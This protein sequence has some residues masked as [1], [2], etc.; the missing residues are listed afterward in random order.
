MKRLLLGKI[1]GT[2]VTLGLA[3]QSVAAGLLSI[4]GIQGTSAIPGKQGWINIES[5][6]WGHGTLP[7]AS[8]KTAAPPEFQPITI[9][10]QL[11]ATSPILA[12]AATPAGMNHPKAAIEL[13]IAG[14][15][16]QVPYA[17]IELEQVRVTSYQASA[18]GSGSP[19][20]TESITLSYGKIRWVYFPTDPRGG[21][22]GAPVTTGFDLRTG[23]KF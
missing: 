8:G 19:A 11:D 13:T 16:T 18:N 23:Q 21:K 6:Q 5:V 4:D 9:V 1:L 7:S 3:G 20:P 12:L 17:R 2:M 22:A 10:K 14:R 15:E